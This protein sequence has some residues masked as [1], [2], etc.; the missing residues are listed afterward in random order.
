MSTN[1]LKKQNDNSHKQTQIINR[2][3]LIPDFKSTQINSNVPR[4]QEIESFSS[5]GFPS[6]K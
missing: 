4:T 1:C 6:L 5:S 3:P 2:V